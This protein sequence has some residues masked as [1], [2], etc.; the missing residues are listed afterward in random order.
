MKRN[1]TLVTTLFAVILASPM[2][3]GTPAK[4]DPGDGEERVEAILGP[5]LIGSWVVNVAEGATPPF[6]AL[7]T[8]HRGGTVDE[9]SDLLGQ[10]GEGPGH[11][12]WERTLDGYAVTFELFIFEP[13]G[14]PA[15]RIRVRETI[16]MTGNGTFTGFSVADLILPGGTVIEKI[17]GAPITGTR[18]DVRAV[19]A[20]E[21]GSPANAIARPIR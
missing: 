5:T 20:E 10:G 18:I 7:Q 3:Y 21:I 13:D 4:S 1:I 12:A 6:T 14:A 17:D 9:T 2:I 15:G 19:R 16:T 8:F 11:G